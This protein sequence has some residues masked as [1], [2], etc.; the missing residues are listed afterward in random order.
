MAE[1]IHDDDA[2]RAAVIFYG[3]TLLVISVL[4][5]VLWASVT[6][7]RHVLSPR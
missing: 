1:A 5:G 3:G 6:R 7:D 2:A 4:L